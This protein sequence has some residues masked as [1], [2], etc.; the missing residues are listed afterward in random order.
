MTGFSIEREIAKETAKVTRRPSYN[1]SGHVDVVLNVAGAEWS[2]EAE[3]RYHYLPAE[4]GS[5]E[6]GSGIQLE[7]DYAEG[8]EIVSVSI[9]YSERFGN[10]TQDKKLD[11]TP[12]VDD[13]MAAAIQSQLMEE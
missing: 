7:P 6:K 2:G 3:V 4:R 9:L 10:V 12:L 5:R 8:I 11:I 13:D 1:L